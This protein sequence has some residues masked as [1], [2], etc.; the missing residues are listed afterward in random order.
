VAGGQG[1]GDVSGGGG[2]VHAA[3]VGQGPGEGGFVKYRLPWFRAGGGGA[4]NAS[5][6]ALPT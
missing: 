5:S 3:A 4:S 1:G 2:G 6:G